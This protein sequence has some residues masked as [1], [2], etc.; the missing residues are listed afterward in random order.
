MNPEFGG[1]MGVGKTMGRVTI[2]DEVTVTW[3]AAVELTA[4]ARPAP[5]RKMFFML[6]AYHR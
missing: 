3:A 4:S 2:T 5:I 6:L 1:A